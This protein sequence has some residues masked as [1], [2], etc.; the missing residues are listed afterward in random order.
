MDQNALF[1]VRFPRYST[2]SDCRDFCSRLVQCV[3]VDFD[4][5]ADACWLHFD[6]AN[7][8]QDNIYHPPNVAQFVLDRRCAV[9]ET[10]TTVTTTTTTSTT[11]ILFLFM[12]KET[13]VHA[14]RLECLIHKRDSHPSTADELAGFEDLD[15]PTLVLQ[16]GRVPRVVGATLLPSSSTNAK[17]S[18]SSLLL[19]LF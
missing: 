17:L 8:R 7:L 15:H 4:N 16:T 9:T 10:T 19:L 18:A 1:A 6:S 14:T 12:L 5:N 13:E 3:A 2:P 11:S